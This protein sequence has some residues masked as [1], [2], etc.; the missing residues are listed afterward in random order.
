MLATERVAISDRVKGECDHKERGMNESVA[1]SAWCPNRE[2]FNPSC[3]WVRVDG[4]PVPENDIAGKISTGNGRR[5]SPGS[6]NP[7]PKEK[8]GGVL[9]SW[10]REAER[11]IPLNNEGKGFAEW[12]ALVGLLTEMKPLNW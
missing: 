12:P 3:D 6:K 11:R 1:R 4:V 9:E 5:E 7:H 10:P 2:A 8:S